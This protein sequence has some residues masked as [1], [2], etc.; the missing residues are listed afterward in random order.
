MSNRKDSEKVAKIV[1]DYWKNFN[2]EVDAGDFSEWLVA[3]DISLEDYKAALP[4]ARKIIDNNFSMDSFK[5]YLR[6]NT[7]LNKVKEHL[8]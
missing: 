6:L 5:R 3:H 7:A 2:N 4:S 1:A 8:K